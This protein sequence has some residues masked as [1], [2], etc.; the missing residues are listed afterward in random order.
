VN[1]E[2]DPA[3]GRELE[4]AED[5]GARFMRQIRDAQ[6]DAGGAFIQAAA[7]AVQ[8]FAEFFPRGGALHR[9]VARQQ[10]TAI[11]H[12]GDARG[13]IAAARAVIDRRAPLALRVPTRHAP[14]THFQFQRR[15]DAVARFETVVLR[16]LPVRMQIDE[17]RG[18]HQALGVDGGARRQ[19][20]GG[21]G[22]DL[23]AADP[24][25]AHGVEVGGRV[26]HAPVGDGQIVGLRE[27]GKSEEHKRE[28]HAEIVPARDNIQ[29][30]SPTETE[31]IEGVLA[32][33]REAPAALARLING[34]PEST[35]RRPPAPG[36][37]SVVAVLAHLAE[38]ELSSSWRYRQMLE[39]PGIALASFDQEEWARRG[40]YE[41][42]DPHEAL[43]MFRLLREANLRLLAGLTA[44]E[45]QS[46]SMHA[47]RGRITVADLAL[48]MPEHDANHIEQ[49]RRSLHESSASPNPSRDR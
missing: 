47:E 40:D 5:F 41:S 38:D 28:P 16:S 8:D 18:H 22:R 43:E 24:D 31:A 13:N 39:Q 42:W 14:H 36:K 45:W 32:R 19:R 34:V 27:K 46:W 37:W 3:R 29:V 33:Q 25:V 7:H 2:R 4:E 21:D 49:I 15:G 10:C 44:E 48:H 6:S 35:L 26:Q 1:E 17:A 30:P 11:V 12:H 23:A 20:P 9:A